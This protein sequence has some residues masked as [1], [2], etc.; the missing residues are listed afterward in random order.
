MC[1]VCGSVI[2]RFDSLFE[3]YNGMQNQRLTREQ[4]ERAAED[5]AEEFHR[6]G[7]GGIFTTTKCS[8]DD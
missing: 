4:S 3:T 5:I 1:G 7:P 2:D 6:E 8:C